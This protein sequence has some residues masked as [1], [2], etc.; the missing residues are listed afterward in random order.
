MGMNEGTFIC[1]LLTIVT[2]IWGFLNILT[3]QMQPPRLQPLRLQSETKEAESTTAKTL[4]APSPVIPALTAEEERKRLEAQLEARHRE[5]WS[6]KFEEQE[7]AR[8]FREIF[9][10]QEYNRQHDEAR[11]LEEAQHMLRDAIYRRESLQR[12]FLLNNR[13]GNWQGGF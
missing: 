2:L 13:M 11:R 8:Y 9:C 7:V 1:C 6:R 10:R 5:E 3:K 12:N 4:V